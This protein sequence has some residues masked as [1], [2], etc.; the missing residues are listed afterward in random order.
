MLHGRGRSVVVDDGLLTSPDVKRIAVAAGIPTDQATGLILRLWFWTDRFTDG[1]SVRDMEIH[2]VDEIVSHDGFGAALAD[3]G[4][5]AAGD[6]GGLALLGPL[7]RP[8]KTTHADRQHRRQRMVSYRRRKAK[9]APNTVVVTLPAHDGQG[10][11][12][13][14]DARNH[15]NLRVLQA[16]AALN[17]IEGWIPRM[18]AAGHQALVKLEADGTNSLDAVRH[19]IDAAER[20]KAGPGWVVNGLRRMAGLEVRVQAERRKQ[21]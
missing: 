10:A 12:F 11:L 6:G 17:R 16:F 13:A 1:A 18:A 15:P 14:G 5:L 19:L 7:R 8:M 9:P 20:R 2:G 3:A 4:W 21:A